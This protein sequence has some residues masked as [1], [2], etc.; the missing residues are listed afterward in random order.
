MKS[1]IKQHSPLAFEPRATAIFVLCRFARP[2]SGSR[3]A[4][5]NGPIAGIF[6]CV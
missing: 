3:R 6:D 5:G 4:I 2:G 1:A